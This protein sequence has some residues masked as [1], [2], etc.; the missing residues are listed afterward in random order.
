MARIIV[1][2]RGSALAIAQVRTVLPELTSEWPDINITQRTLPKEIS[3]TDLLRALES[4]QI[5]IAVVDLGK[6]DALPEGFVFGGITKRL[7]P[8][9][10]LIT[11]GLADLKALGNGALA[12]VI[13]DRDATFLQLNHP[14]LKP[15]VQPDVIDDLLG[16]LSTDD[17]EALVYP[18]SNLI[19]LNRR[20]YADVLIE[21]DVLPPAPGQGSIGLIVRED[22]DLAAEL[23]YSLNHRLSFARVMAERSFADTLRRPGLHIGALATVS[24]ED[25]LRL[26]ATVADTTTGVA[27][28]VEVTGDM[29]EATTLGRELAG[30]VKAQLTSQKR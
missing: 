26:F 28:Q 8:R 12:A 11:K 24:D 9:S 30:D 29:A 6:F 5:Q 15:S 17:V 13:S 20:Q 23:A 4:N 7:E 1:G 14:G 16:S 18:C 21:A 27:L 3:H 2:S 19:Y 25:E 22:D 10:A